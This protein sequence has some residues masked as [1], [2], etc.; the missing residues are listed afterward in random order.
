MFSMPLIVISMVK[1]MGQK[2]AVIIKGRGQG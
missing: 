1:V 2:N